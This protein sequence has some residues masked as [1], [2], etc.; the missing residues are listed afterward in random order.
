MLRGKVQMLRCLDGAADLLL[1]STMHRAVSWTHWC[2]PQMSTVEQSH[3]HFTRTTLPFVVFSFLYNV[4]LHASSDVS[5]VA[6]DNAHTSH[7][8]VNETVL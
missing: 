6:L 4:S 2:T 1:S 5:F 7:F 8:F 3:P